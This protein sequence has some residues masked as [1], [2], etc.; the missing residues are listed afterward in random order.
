MFNSVVNRELGEN[1]LGVLSDLFIHLP[2][3][4]YNIFYSPTGQQQWSDLL[5]H[6]GESIHSRGFPPQ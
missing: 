3:F 1:I 5:Q 2:V 4:Q 6:S